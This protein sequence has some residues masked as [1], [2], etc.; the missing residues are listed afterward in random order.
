MPNYDYRCEK[1]EH[2]FEEFLPMKSR[3]A[4]NTPSNHIKALGFIRFFVNKSGNRMCIG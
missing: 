2:T 4:L 1:C 3:Q